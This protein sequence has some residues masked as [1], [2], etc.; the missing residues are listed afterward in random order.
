M[1][2]E[3]IVGRNFIPIKELNDLLDVSMNEPI[4]NRMT[5]RYDVDDLWKPSFVPEYLND[6]SDVDL[7]GGEALLNG[8]A[9]VY[10]DGKF[11]PKMVSEVV[12][13]LDFIPDVDICS[14]I[15]S[16]NMGLVYDSSQL[17]WVVK[18]IQPTI[19]FLSDISGIDL[20]NI[21]DGNTIA[22]NDAS[23][24]WQPK[25]VGAVINVLDDL[26]DVDLGDLESQLPKWEVTKKIE[27]SDMDVNDNFGS[28]VAMDI[29][30]AVVGSYRKT[31]NVGGLPY[32]YVGSAYVYKRG[33]TSVDWNE[34]QKLLPSLKGPNMRFGTKIAMDSNNIVVTA[35]YFSYIDQNNVTHTEGGAIFVY[36]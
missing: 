5:L 3:G 31:A 11:V 32:T 26:L 23:G 14:N 12:T 33:D 9:L 35:P 6:L 17:K 22:Y 24:N 36:I 8:T 7:S 27:S 15:L 4:Q 28:A 20:T 21:K 18:G 16:N 34:N 1:W 29:S 13:G 2:E 19:E 25:E 30:Y 10:Q